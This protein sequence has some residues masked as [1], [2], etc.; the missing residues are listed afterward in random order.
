MQA[1]KFFRFL[2]EGN[3]VHANF[4]LEAITIACS[5]QLDK[6][7]LS[8]IQRRYELLAEDPIQAWMPNLDHSG[9][10]KLKGKSFS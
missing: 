4:V 9:I 5:P 6:D 7:K 10:D 2:Q 8:A 1:R 3:R